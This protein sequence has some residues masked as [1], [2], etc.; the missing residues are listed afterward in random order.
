[1]NLL[2]KRGSEKIA[3]KDL[4]IIIAK[5]PTIRPQEWLQ[6]F[7]TNYDVGVPTV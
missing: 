1:M 3:A 7:R 2:R 5:A 4:A 6:P